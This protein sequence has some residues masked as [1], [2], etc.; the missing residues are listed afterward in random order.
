MSEAGDILEAARNGGLTLSPVVITDW[1]DGPVEGVASLSVGSAL[2]IF[3]L[4]AEDLPSGTPNDRLFLLSRLRDEIMGRRVMELVAASRLPVIWP[5]D[6]Q[7]DAAA[8]LSA[9]E[10]V[11]ESVVPAT[12]AVN[13]VDFGVVTKAWKIM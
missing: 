3:R 5:F 10:A 12:L 2:W 1:R 4:F 6:D 8:I 11:L 13:L 7:P 9:V